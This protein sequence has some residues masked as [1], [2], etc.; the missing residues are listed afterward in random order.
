[1]NKEILSSSMRHK[2]FHKFNILSN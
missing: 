1:M 2:H